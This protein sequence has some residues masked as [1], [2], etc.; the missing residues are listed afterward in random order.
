MTAAESLPIEEF[1]SSAKSQLIFDVRT[2]SEFA[3]AHIPS[4]RNL[5]LFSD[6]ERAVIGTAYKQESREKAIMHGFE[7]FG[8]KMKLLV[9][10]ALEQSS[11]KDVLVHCWRGGMRSSAVS[12]L[13]NFYGINARTLDGGYK[14]FRNYALRSFDIP[15][16]LLIIGGKT[17]S[18]KTYILNELKK[19]GEQTID[20]ESIAEHH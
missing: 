19:L 20:L 2:P 4:A 10:A 15:Q 12:W 5:A 3:H 17:G 1:L 6:E 9:E 18:G 14:S 7:F 13:L 16:P 11:G 8:P